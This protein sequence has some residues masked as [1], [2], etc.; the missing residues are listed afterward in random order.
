M[1]ALTIW[2]GVFLPHS[3]LQGLSCSK[4]PELKLDKGKQS[5]LVKLSK[6]IFKFSALRVGN[7]AGTKIHIFELFKA[8][9]NLGMF[10]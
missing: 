7:S 3:N 9:A 5:H 2:T 8:Y 1:E 4:P 6:S 10:N